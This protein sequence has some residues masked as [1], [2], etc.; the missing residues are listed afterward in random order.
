MEATEKKK[1]DNGVYFLLA[2]ICGVA[3]AWAVMGTLLW[4][5]IGAVLGLIMAA[6]YVN[7]VIHDKEY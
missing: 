1:N 7:F 6:L 4:I 2:V 5:G 3:T